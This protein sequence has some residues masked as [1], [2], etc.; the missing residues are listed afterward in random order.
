MFRFHGCCPAESCEIETH[1]CTFQYL[2]EVGFGNQM[3]PSIACTKME[4]TAECS[5]TANSAKFPLRSCWSKRHTK[6]WDQG[7]KGIQKWPKYAAIKNINKAT[8]LHVSHTLPAWKKPQLSL[9]RTNASEQ[10][11]FT[12]SSAISSFFVHGYSPNGPRCSCDPGNP[13]QSLSQ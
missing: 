11:Q 7:P 5:Q 1:N 4:R 9:S 12:I 8:W 2:F 6:S 13:N 3:W 10:R